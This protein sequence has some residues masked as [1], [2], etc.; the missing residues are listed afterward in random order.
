VIVEFISLAI[1]KKENIKRKM[2]FLLE[3]LSEENVHDK[4]GRGETG[5]GTAKVNNH[6]LKQF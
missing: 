1:K 2:P 3:F 5:R 4:K 6:I